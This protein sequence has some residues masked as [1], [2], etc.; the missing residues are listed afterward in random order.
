[1]KNHAIK[2]NVKII[3]MPR[4]G[5]GLDKLNWDSVKNTIIDTDIK[6]NIFYI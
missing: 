6:I 3:S 2:N 4:I 5:S 1:M